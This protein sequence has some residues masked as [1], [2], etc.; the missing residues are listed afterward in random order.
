LNFFLAELPFRKRYFITTQHSLAVKSPLFCTIFT[1]DLQE[2]LNNQAAITKF[3][4][5]I[6]K[7]TINIEGM[8]VGE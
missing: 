3:M 6:Y 2:T 1:S 5:D 4:T 8:K 7:K